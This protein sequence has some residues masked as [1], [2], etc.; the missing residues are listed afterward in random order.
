MSLPWQVELMELARPIPASVATRPAYRAS[1]PTPAPRQVPPVPQAPPLLAQPVPPAGATQL[2][3]DRQPGRRLSRE[4][5][6]ERRRLGLCF[7]CN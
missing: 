4:E 2:S 5:Q 1:L 6:E 3:A 7:N